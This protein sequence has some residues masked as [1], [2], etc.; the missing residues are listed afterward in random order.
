MLI[1]CL[2]LL[3]GCSKTSVP[4]GRMNLK[5]ED[6]PQQVLDSIGHLRRRLTV[7]KEIQK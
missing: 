4:E 3:A 1:A 6:V 7:R 5:L 2:A